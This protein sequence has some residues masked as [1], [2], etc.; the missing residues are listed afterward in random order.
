MKIEV[1]KCY[2]LRNG[3]KVGPMRERVGYFPFAFDGRTWDVDGRY[4]DTE[5]PDPMD[6]VAEYN[7]PELEE[8]SI[9]ALVGKHPSLVAKLM[10]E[11]TGFRED[12]V[13][14]AEKLAKDLLQDG[15]AYRS[16]TQT[17]T[18]FLA[19]CRFLVESGA[20]IRYGRDRVEVGVWL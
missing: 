14:L 19:A 5:R 15:C 1:G 8:E 11:D 3:E 2:V 6:I 12:A 9:V 13:T 18:L 7:E 10:S 17:D 16:P 4:V 20:S